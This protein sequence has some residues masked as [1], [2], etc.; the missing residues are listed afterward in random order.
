MC[1]CYIFHL[2]TWACSHLLYSFPDFVWPSKFSTW[3]IQFSPLSLRALYTPRRGVFCRGSD[4]FEKSI[5]SCS[6]CHFW[7]SSQSSAVFPTTANTCHLIPQNFPLVPPCWHWQVRVIVDILKN[8]RNYF[9]KKLFI[10]AIRSV[11]FTLDQFSSPKHLKY[12][13]PLNFV[14]SFKVIH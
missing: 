2:F 9:K 8:I 7:P 6:R 11:N 13:F 12:F 3:E 10:E 4:N 5:V 1:T 14:A